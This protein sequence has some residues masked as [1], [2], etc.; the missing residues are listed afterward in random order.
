MHYSHNRIGRGLVTLARGAGALAAALCIVVTMSGSASAASERGAKVYL[1]RGFM[2]IFSLGLD[3]LQSKIERRGIRA[4]VYAHTSAI[5]LV[6]EIAEGYK[7]GKTRPV[8]LIGHSAGA[9]AIVDLVGEL[10]RV[11][12][13]VALAVTLDISSR[14]VPAGRVGTFLNLY[15]STGALT[16]GPGFHGNL[17]NMDMTRNDPTVGHFSIDK[18]EQIH[19][20]ILRYVSSAAGRGGGAPKRQSSQATAPEAPRS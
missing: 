15:A 4:E 20:L 10:E 8:I 11:G 17:V 19:N 18:A 3:D 2:N 14:P 16:K 5:R 6:N 7:S 12:V 1:L 13:P 9:S